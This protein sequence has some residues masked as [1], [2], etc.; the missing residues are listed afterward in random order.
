VSRGGDN[1]GA[2]ADGVRSTSEA[3]TRG[4]R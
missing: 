3:L 2:V 1:K 4:E